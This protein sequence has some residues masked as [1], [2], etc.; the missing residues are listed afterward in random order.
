MSGKFS[1]GAIA[2]LIVGAVLAYGI[3]NME[4]P[5]PKN[6]HGND[7]LA[8]TSRQDHDD[9]KSQNKPVQRGKHGGWLFAERDFQ[10]EV[11]IYEDGIPPQFRVYITSHEGEAISFKE[12]SLNIVLKRLDRTDTIGFKP[13]GDY[14][15]G[16][17][18]VAEPH[19]FDM[20]VNAKWKGKNFQWEISQIEG[21]AEFSPEAIKNAGLVFKKVRSAKLASTIRLPGEIGLNEEKLVHIVPRVNGVVTKVFK[22]LGDRVSA[23]EI[24]AILESQE[25]ADSKIGYLARSKQVDLARAD[26]DRETLLFENTRKML[27][28]LEKEEDLEVI[29]R[30]LNSRVIG[31]SREL[32]IPA[33]AKLRLAKSIHLQ[34][35]GLFEKGITAETD[36]L[37]A[38]EDYKSAEARYIALREKISYD[39]DWSSSRKEK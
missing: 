33:Y 8:E 6:P 29:D 9:R 26:L 36:Y 5:V 3:M 21:R 39:G 15:L 38:W 27:E 17:K 13:S 25:L 24:I 14:L 11:K 30:Q 34:E 32:L 35:K 19:S 37:L 22:D 10:V 4:K 28:L 20:I 16:D 31:K 12:I 23:G 2:I 1:I 7:E 18:V